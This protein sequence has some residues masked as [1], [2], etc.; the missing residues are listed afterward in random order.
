M[1]SDPRKSFAFGDER[2]RSVLPGEGCGGP[3][4]R[5]SQFR[6]FCHIQGNSTENWKKTDPETGKFVPLR[7]EDKTP[8]HKLEPM[9]SY[10]RYRWEKGWRLGK[11]IALD[12]MTI[13]FKGR[14]ALVTRIK[15]KREGDGFQ[16]D[17][18][19]ESGYCF[20]FWFRCDKP[21][22]P[23]PDNVSAR[24]SRCCWLVERLPGMWYHLWM[25]NLFTSFKFG[26]MLAERQCLFGGTCQ[27]A[28]WRGMH[29]AVVQKEEKTVKGKEAARGKLLA[30]YRSEGMPENC[31]VICASYYDTQ[32][33][34][35]FHM[36]SNIIEGIAVVEVR[37]RCFSTA[38]LSHFYVTL[39]RMSLGH[40]YSQHM[41][42]V[43]IAD[44]LRMVYRPD[45]LW[46]RCRKWW[47][48]IM[49]WA[50]GQAVTNAY[51]QYTDVCAR[52]GAKAIT[53]L[54]FRVAVSEVWC[55]TPEIVLDGKE[56]K[57]A[58]A[59]TLVAAETG[60]KAPYLTEKYLVKCAA[61]Y[62]ENP[63]AHQ[64]E[65]HEQQESGKDKIC[66]LCDKDKC[67]RVGRHENKQCM[68]CL[69]CGIGVCS[70]YCWKWL[71]GIHEK[72]CKPCPGV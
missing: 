21:P 20:T 4:R 53:H 60:K 64:P 59:A 62:A 31:E 30:S 24:D 28:D 37:K 66:Q 56:K 72:Q 10:M 14:C 63:L 35:P 8:M 65:E 48:S 15:Y 55:K 68:R 11:N 7:F 57:S 42:S 29:S 61:S 1:F 49:L 44:Q 17:A 71:H 46:M 26:K 52:A 2:A 18:I 23:V 58:T 13:G 40:L 34:K 27:T 16:C 39:H 12:E 25:D 32:S 47:W 9:L 33:D 70:A 51:K 36:M 6:S 67:G 19:C 38:T 5:F 50:L 41:N 54:D 22:R 3:A 69:C 45:G 43:D